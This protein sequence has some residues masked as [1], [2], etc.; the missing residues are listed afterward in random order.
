MT[1]L[2]F[3]V[4]LLGGIGTTLALTAGSF[5]IGAV[6]GIPIALGRISRFHALRFLAG[7]YIEIVRGIPP[8]AWLFLLFFGL[9]QFGIRL[10]SFVA[11]LIA[12]GVISGGYLAEIYRAGLNAVPSGQR[13]A[14]MALSI[15]S[16][17]AFQF[18][19]APQAVIT[20]LPLAV[21][22]FIGLLKDS[23][24]ASVIGVQDITTIALGLSRRSLDALTIFAA[25]GLVYLLISI[26]IGLLGR[27]AGDT[28]SKKWG[29]RVAY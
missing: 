1:F 29:A 15:S 3:F 24:V 4:A 2:D 8:I 23:A 6:L 21:A 26:P 10:N 11:A 18:V 17:T 22:F 28:L 7:A 25:A 16:R 5:A 19:I 27:W 14:A 12:L 13:E 20:I 9:N